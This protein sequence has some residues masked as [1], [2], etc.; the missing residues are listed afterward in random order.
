MI[1]VNVQTEEELESRLPLSPKLRHSV[2]LL[3]ELPVVTDRIKELIDAGEW[4]KAAEEVA[5]RDELLTGLSKVIKTLKNE[6]SEAWQHHERR[7]IRWVL[8][9]LQS[10]N[11]QLVAEVRQKVA[12]LKKDIGG[13]QKG[14]KALHLYRRPYSQDSRF[15][16]R[17]G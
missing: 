1:D 6:K 15:F 16:N 8:E 17:F 5:R 10:E 2:E 9:D 11:E 3:G 7:K 14:R 12:L 4:E 13:L